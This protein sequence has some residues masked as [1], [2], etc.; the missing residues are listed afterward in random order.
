M[1]MFKIVLERHKVGFDGCLNPD[2]IP[3]MEDW[4][5][6]STEWKTIH[7]IPFNVFPHNPALTIRDP[8]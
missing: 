8:G 3:R 1:N 7:I 4:P 5:V 2:H 6:M